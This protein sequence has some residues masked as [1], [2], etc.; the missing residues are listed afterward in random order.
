MT[1]RISPLSLYKLSPFEIIME[2]LLMMPYSSWLAEASNL[3]QSDIFRY[4]NVSKIYSILHQQIKTAFPLEFPN[5][6]LYDLEICDLVFSKCHHWKT[7][8]EPR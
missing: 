3:T 7:Y 6:P 8:L 2:R 1:L 5:Y 4:P